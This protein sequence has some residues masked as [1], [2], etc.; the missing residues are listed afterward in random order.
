MVAGRNESAPCTLRQMVGVDDRDGETA[1][2]LE[3]AIAAIEA[4]KRGQSA[5]DE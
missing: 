5:P 4:M 2:T 1:M 3:E